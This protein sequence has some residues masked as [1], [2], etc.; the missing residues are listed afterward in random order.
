MKGNQVQKTKPCVIDL[1]VTVTTEKP[2][3]RHPSKINK[4]TT[5]RM[6]EN[7]CKQCDQQ[8]INLQNIQMFHTALYQKKK[9]AQ[10][11]GQKI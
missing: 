8:G 10:L 11:N 7:L 1:P 5:L 2:F 9:S 4:K 6:G 3:T